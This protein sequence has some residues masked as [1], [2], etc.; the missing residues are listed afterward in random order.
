MTEPRAP[1]W[2]CRVRVQ[3]EAISESRVEAAQGAR[4]ELPHADARFGPF[5]SRASVLVRLEPVCAAFRRF[6]PAVAGRPGV[7]EQRSLAERP[8]AET[9]AS[10]PLAISAAFVGVP[11]I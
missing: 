11:V 10:E 8:Q 5:A 4:E 7:R 9:P 3:F 1:A 2:S 6:H